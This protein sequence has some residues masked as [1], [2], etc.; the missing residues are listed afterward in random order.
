MSSD[1]EA[2]RDASSLSDEPRTPQIYAAHRPVLTWK[3]VD[4]LSL[5]S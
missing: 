1:T 4:F 3:D 2:Y 5:E